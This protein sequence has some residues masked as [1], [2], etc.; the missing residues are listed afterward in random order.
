MLSRQKQHFIHL[1]KS[2]AKAHSHQKDS[3]GVGVGLLLGLQAKGFEDDA[4]ALCPG[5]MCENAAE[6]NALVD[7]AEQRALFANVAYGVGA[8]ALVGAAVLWFT[9]APDEA[10]AEHAVVPRVGPDSVAL[11][12]M[13]RF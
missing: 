3:I 6:A 13:V 5:V 12:V 7:K 8:A 10:P 1:M 9:G 11:D 4:A 2:T